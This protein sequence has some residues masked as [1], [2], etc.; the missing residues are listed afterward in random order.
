VALR[1]LDVAG[2]PLTLGR[3]L[4]NHVVLDDPW[5]APEHATIGRDHEGRLVLLVGD[6]RNGVVLDGR[7]LAS[8]ERAVLPEAGATLQLGATQVRLRL[9]GEALA[10]ERLLPGV[11]PGKR[12]QLAGVAALLLALVLF[13][14][15]VDIDPGGDYSAW[16]PVI[17]GI[18]VAVVAWCGAWA[19]LSKLFQHRFDFGG[20]LR[21]ALPW[22]LAM[23]LAD[24]LLPQV[25]AMLAA[26]WLWY[27]N[28]PVA[29]LLSALLVHA[30]LAHVLPQHRRMVAASVAALLVGG[31]ALAM[32]QS[33]RSTDSLRPQPYM[34]TLP[35][36]A[37][38][39]AGTVPPA[40]LA[41][42]VPTLVKAIDRRVQKAQRDEPELD[43]D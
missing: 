20:H 8:G 10:P 2:W 37:L 41:E 33:W 3:S 7:T 34:S 26:P 16:L 5:V 6:T 11:V 28:G 15:W 12:A 32:A 19:L 29:A 17:V 13:G 38:R 27:L 35:L 21:I 9:P 24:V 1:A 43:A 23:T 31:G 36:P 42:D 25:G 18:P 30:H 39:L 22:L 4:A 40:T 14:H